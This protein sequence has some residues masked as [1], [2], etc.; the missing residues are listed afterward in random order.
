MLTVLGRNHPEA[1]TWIFC[2]PLDYQDW[3]LLP[4]EDAGFSKREGCSQSVQ[5]ELGF[6]FRLVASPKEI[7][8][9]AEGAA[10]TGGVT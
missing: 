5:E 2:N 10:A 9:G 1:I 4:P 3:Q 6:S 7:H 8:M